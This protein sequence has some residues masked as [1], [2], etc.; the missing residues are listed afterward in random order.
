MCGLPVGLMPVSEIGGISASSMIFVVAN[1]NPGSAGSFRSE[2][3]SGGAGVIWAQQQAGWF[4]QKP[5]G[6]G[7]LEA[8]S[9]Y[10]HLIIQSGCNNM[11]NTDI[12]MCVN[13]LLWSPKEDSSE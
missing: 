2:R 1:Y 10:S 9:F 7:A 12:I 11:K 8:L 6:I 13:V 3:G 5:N 4:H